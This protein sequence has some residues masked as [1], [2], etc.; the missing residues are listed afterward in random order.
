VALDL[1]CGIGAITLQLAGHCRKVLGVEVF[2]QA[3]KDAARNASIN[4]FDHVSFLAGPAGETMDKVSKADVLVA[5]PPRSGLEKG[6][7]RNLKR[8]KPTKIAYLSCDPATMARDISL[9]APLGYRVSNL[10]L[11]DMF[12]QTYHIE[13]LAILERT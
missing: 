12:P 10:W 2:P 3:V 13:A 9:V 5:D 7:V 11:A 8:L 4:G 6:V 1:Y